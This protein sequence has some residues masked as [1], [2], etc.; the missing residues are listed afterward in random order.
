MCFADRTGVD[1]VRPK[2]AEVDGQVG[3][4]GHARHQ[5][6]RGPVPACV[7]R[8]GV[9]GGTRDAGRSQRGLH[10]C[11]A[12]PVGTQGEVNDAL[13]RGGRGLPRC[14][15][16]KGLLREQRGAQHAPA[17]VPFTVDAILAWADAHH[18]RTAKC[19]D[20]RSGP[21]PECPGSTWTAVETALTSG[22]RSRPGGSSISR[23]LTERRAIG[24]RFHPPDLTIRQ[25]LAWAE[26]FL[27]RT[28]QWPKRTSGPIL[29]A[30]AKAGAS[31][32]APSEPAG[33]ASRAVCPSIVYATLRNTTNR[34]RRVEG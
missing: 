9:R 10:A 2:S 13:R 27:A 15:T 18:A 30:P 28:G 20:R 8:A 32:S 22:G 7:E 21:I 25:I 17:R 4:D 14:A 5:Q 31:S 3:F 26:A 19:P 11:F 6:A 23:L 33:A 16:L 34:P 29:E 12:L 1:L 24:Y